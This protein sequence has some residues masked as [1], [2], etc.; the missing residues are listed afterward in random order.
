MGR[1][2]GKD[3]WWVAVTSVAA[4]RCSGGGQGSRVAGQP[5]LRCPGRQ[6]PGAERCG[7]RSGGPGVL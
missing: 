4:G 3:S 6:S 2:V 7:G 5:G 1:L